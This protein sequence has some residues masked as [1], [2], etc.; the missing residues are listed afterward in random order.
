MRAKTDHLELHLFRRSRLCKTRKKLPW[1]P[2]LER[3]DN[4]KNLH[5]MVPIPSS[6]CLET[7]SFD[8]FGSLRARP[9]KNGGKSTN[10]NFDI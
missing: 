2:D 7:P 5:H 3:I 1:R 4:H 9:P 6:R 8:Y 10:D